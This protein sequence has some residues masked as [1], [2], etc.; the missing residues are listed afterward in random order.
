MDNR[1]EILQNTGGIPGFQIFFEIIISHP[2][3]DLITVVGIV[4]GQAGQFCTDGFIDGLLFL[5]QL[6]KEK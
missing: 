5:N 6:A 3:Q 1:S 2:L 4:F